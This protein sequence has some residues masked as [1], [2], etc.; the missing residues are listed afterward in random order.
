MKW[1]TD[2]HWSLLRGVFLSIIML[3]TTFTAFSINDVNA[4]Q[5]LVKA[6]SF[7]FEKTTIIEFENQQGGSE[8]ETIRIWL[9]SD[10]T[11][12][13]FKTEKGWT[14]KKT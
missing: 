12:K 2:M 13:S 11:F 4:Q 14:G 1:L 5:K 7:A 8:I 9:G 6:E 10:F 3:A